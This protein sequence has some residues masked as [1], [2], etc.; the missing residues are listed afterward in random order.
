MKKQNKK[1]A[2][3]V[4]EEEDGEYVKI[5]D[6]RMEALRAHLETCVKLS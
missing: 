2:K 6:P 1:D 3:D 5:A 4:S